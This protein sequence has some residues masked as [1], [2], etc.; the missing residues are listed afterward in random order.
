[1]ASGKPFDG[2]KIHRIGSVESSCGQLNFSLFIEEHGIARVGI[3]A[4]DPSDRRKSGVLT[5][6]SGAEYQKPWKLLQRTDDAIAAAKAS[7][8][9]KGLASK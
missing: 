9:M 1:M 7:R 4:S 8:D 5:M 2:E 3:Y 6:L